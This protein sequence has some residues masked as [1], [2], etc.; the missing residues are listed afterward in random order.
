MSQL[1]TMQD[2]FA[3]LLAAIGRARRATFFAD[4]GCVA[5]GGGRRIAETG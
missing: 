5:G 4:C 1:K 2:E 3:N